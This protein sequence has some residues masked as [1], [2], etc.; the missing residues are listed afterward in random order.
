M[1]T[2]ALRTAL[3]NIKR[4]SVVR[5][6]RRTLSVLTRCRRQSS[7]PTPTSSPSSSSPRRATGPARSSTIQ[8]TPAPVVDDDATEPA[9][10]VVLHEHMTIT[11]AVR[12]P[13]RV[14]ST[15][16]TLPPLRTCNA[17]PVPLPRARTVSLST[18]MNMAG[19][20]PTRRTAAVLAM[21]VNGVLMGRESPELA[22]V[23][24][25]AESMAK[26]AEGAISGELGFWDCLLATTTSSAPCQFQQA[27]LRTD[28]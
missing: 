2:N 18:T 26:G 7:H 25:E 9:V 27:S 19:V 11:A 1:P 20:R 17:A 4:A 8:P 14:A 21:E 5:N 12:I 24:E 15:K 16:K 28:H 10:P 22:A 3:C 6:A 23:E 13:T